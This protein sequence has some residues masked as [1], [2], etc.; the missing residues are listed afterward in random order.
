MLQTS[1]LSDL[2]VVV[3]YRCRPYIVE[4]SIWILNPNTF[5]T[6]KLAKNDRFFT[7]WKE[8]PVEMKSKPFRFFFFA[9]ISGFYPSAFV[10]IQKSRSCL[11]DWKVKDFNE[12]EVWRNPC[13]GN[14]LNQYRPAVLIQASLK[15]KILPCMWFMRFKRSWSTRKCTVGTNRTCSLHTQ[16]PELEL[17]HQLSVFP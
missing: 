13:F 3:F 9:Q 16:W 6:E 2:P 15:K 17:N 4:V 14:P 11:F 12:S 1:V 8:V 5:R 7:V 10:N